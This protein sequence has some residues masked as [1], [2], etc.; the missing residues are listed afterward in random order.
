MGECGLRQ[1]A[2]T[3]ELDS[4]AL[5]PHFYNYAFRNAFFAVDK[6]FECTASTRDYMPPKA[7]YNYRM[8]YQE[9]RPM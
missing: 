9:T 8:G 2:A 3:P 4:S 5:C 7:L 1:P 6:P